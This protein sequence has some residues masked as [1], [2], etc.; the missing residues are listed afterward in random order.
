MDPLNWKE[1]PFAKEEE[2][3]V[4]A[5]KNEPLFLTSYLTGKLPVRDQGPWS[6]SYTHLTLPTIYSV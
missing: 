5:F 1:A 2:T 4:V 6:V 3:T